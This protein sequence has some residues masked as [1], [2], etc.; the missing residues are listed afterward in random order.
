MK[1]KAKFVITVVAD[2]D[3]IDEMKRDMEST[4]ETVRGSTDDQK[5]EEGMFDYD[6][7]T[8]SE[9]LL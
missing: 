4:K 8:E 2:D 6:F 1:K 9:E 7:A 5:I 3:I